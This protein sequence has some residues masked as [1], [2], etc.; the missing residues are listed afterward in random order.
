MNDIWYQKSVSAQISTSDYDDHFDNSN[1][2]HTRVLVII[3][4]DELL[5]KDTDEEWSW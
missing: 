4:T 2:G 1:Y 3:P 5:T